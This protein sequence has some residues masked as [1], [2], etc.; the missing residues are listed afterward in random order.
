M[1]ANIRLQNQKHW[2]LFLSIQKYLVEK[3]FGWLR[4]YID[5]DTKALIGKGK[6]RI[7]RKEYEILL[8]YSPFHKYRYDRIFINDNC[9]EYRED[10]HLYIDNSLCLY[11]PLID[12]PLFQIMPLYRMVPWISEWIVWYEHWKIYGVWLGEEIRH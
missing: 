1:V 8:S 5:S 6:L 4:L 11:H 2:F 7:N 9:I 3:N 10:N 12:K